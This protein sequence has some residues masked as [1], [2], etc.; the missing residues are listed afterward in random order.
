MR[1]LSRD[2]ARD[3]SRDGS[4]DRLLIAVRRAIAAVRDTGDLAEL[5]LLE[6][7]GSI[8]RL[9]ITTAD[10]NWPDLAA[11]HAIGVARWLQ[12]V[13]GAEG[14]YH[15]EREASLRPLAHVYARER[16]AV[17]SEAAAVLEALRSG[18]RLNGPRVSREVRRQVLAGL[19]RRE[20]L[21]QEFVTAARGLD[22]HGGRPYQ[23]AE[24]LRPFLG[25]T[26]RHRPD[27]VRSLRLLTVT[28]QTAHRETG[29][30]AAL[31]EAVRL[32]RELLLLI[33]A[34]GAHWADAV[35]HHARVIGDHYRHTHE[36][37]DLDEAIDRGREA[38]R[39]T[40]PDGEWLAARL[41]TFGL[42]LSLRHD[43]TGAIADLHAAIDACRG[44]VRAAPAESPDATPHRAR[45]AGLLVKRHRAT[46]DGAALDEAVQLVRGEPQP[47]PTPGR[48]GVLD[49]HAEVLHAE[50]R[51][52]GL[53]DVLHDAIALY[54]QAAEERRARGGN[55]TALA[56][57]LSRLGNAL[58]D[59]CA[60]PH[61]DDHPDQADHF[62]HPHGSD[63]P[64]PSEQVGPF[65]QL[66]RPDHS[67]HSAPA[68]ADQRP[69]EPPLLREAIT[70][71]REAVAASGADD[72]QRPGHLRDLARSLCER[73]RRTG[74]PEAL[75]EAIALLR[76]AIETA[77]PAH[78]VRSG[79][80]AHLTAALLE[81]QR[82][83][84]GD[85]P[86]TKLLG[87]A[88]TFAETAARN[89]TGAPHELIRLHRT[90]AEL[91][92]A[93]GRHQEAAA[94]YA[95]AVAPLPQVVPHQLHGST[96]ETQLNG[97][98]RGLAADA[99][100]AVLTAGGPD[101]PARALEVLERARGTLLTS[102]LGFHGED[103][104]L[105]ATA[106]QL[107]A[108]L[109]ELRIALA[110]VPAASDRRH[111][112]A[113]QWGALLAEI[114][115]LPGLDGF[116]RPPRLAALRPAAAG[117]PV[118]TVNTSPLRC[119]ALILTSSGVTAVPL[120]A[121]SYDEAQTRAA[122]FAEAWRTAESPDAAP[123]ARHAAQA[124]LR[125]TLEWLWDTTAAPALDHLART[126]DHHTPDDRAG[127]SQLPRIWLS[128]TG[129]LALLPLHAAGHH[130][131]PD[132]TRTLLDRAVLS[133]T[134]TVAALAAAVRAA[135]RR[136]ARPHRLAPLVV[137]LPRTPGFAPLPGAPTQAQDAALHYGPDTV[138]LDDEEATHTR[139]LAALP[140][141]N[142]LHFAGRAVADPTHPHIDHLIL[143]DQPLTLSEISR[144]RLTDAEFCYLSTCTTTGPD[145]LADE[146]VHLGAAMHLAGFTQVVAPLWPVTDTTATH[147][148]RLFHTSPH[149]TPAH[150][151]HQTIRTL[152]AN[153][154]SQ[155]NQWAAQAHYG[156]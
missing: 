83:T 98:A 146:A 124:Y 38:L 101:A 151:L 78:G 130:T 25:L 51:R 74:R 52:T 143:H 14:A 21:S 152:R 97:H 61:Y 17:P 100:A 69:A 73:A 137:A 5:R 140:A 46:G 27:R 40:P 113:E 34:G 80:L 8:T 96:S 29:D 10:T 120:P 119:D 148:A 19:R 134:P 86:E 105:R 31:A 103:E 63:H 54:R 28:L 13:A 59:H 95:R 110:T 135:S 23:D 58:H 155:P 87:E 139:L 24:A 117:G 6:R 4:R 1:E 94:A 118:V 145:R 138:L 66:D 50:Y 125:A 85:A 77:R 133:Y 121:L 36:R 57:A 128:A 33:P 79:M 26:P 72:P 65:D 144:L 55:S 15:A 149:P 106:P 70:V 84:D 16:D 111:Q 122:R 37:Q 102:A 60:D 88:H 92:T 108:R 35:A 20:E 82:H 81:R 7:Q 131:D 129:P 53:A 76:E 107:A 18:R 32:G 22:P 45:L 99:A 90:L 142:H 49:Q 127:A 150:A 93:T 123:A 136:G 141:A 9:V 112:L 115:H 64:D 42:H 71:H 39:H 153:A 43:V 48:D 67:A 89:A 11:L 154:P 75:D 126:P 62:D 47:L 109:A 132:G 12:H 114:R 41:D 30:A 116:R 44:A 104:T 3:S 91:A 2:P 147:T 68:P 56:N 156:P